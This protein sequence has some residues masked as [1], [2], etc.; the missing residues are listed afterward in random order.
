VLP[1]ILAALVLLAIAPAAASAA[2]GDY[3][4]Q[5]NGTDLP[6]DEELQ[7][8][9]LVLFMPLDESV[10]IALDAEITP[11]TCAGECFRVS[12][13]GESVKYR[14][15]SG[16]Y[17]SD[18]EKMYGAEVFKELGVYYVPAEAFFTAIGFDTRW[19]EETGTLS[20]GYDVELPSAQDRLADLLNIKKP[21]E[22]K[23]VEAEAAPAVELPEAAETYLDYTFENTTRYEYIGVTG[24]A[25]RSRTEEKNDV[26][27]RFNLRYMGKLSSGYDF[28]GVFRSRMTS[29]DE[30]NRGEL[31]KLELNWKKN[32]V[33]YTL[34]DVQPKFGLRYIMRNYSFQGFSYNRT[35]NLFTIQATV[36]KSP[37][38]LRRS[39]YARYINAFRLKKELSK[40]HATVLGAT[41]SLVKDTGSPKPGVVK[42]EN[43]VTGLDLQTRLGAP[44]SLNAEAAASHNSFRNL[45]SDKGTA[46]LYEL[47][48]ST[49][50]SSM[51][52]TYQ[53]TGAGFYSETSTFTRARTEAALLYNHKLGTYAMF[54]G[55]AKHKK[56][57]D[58]TTKIYPLTFSCRP[59][60]TR[61][62]FN[63]KLY[64]NFEKTSGSRQQIIDTREVQLRDALG[65]NR[66][67]LKV[68]RQKN[69]IPGRQLAYRDRKTLSVRSVLT[70]RL[71]SR[72]D[73]KNER[74]KKDRVSVSRQARMKLEFEPKAWT[75]WAAEVSRYY[76]TPSSARTATSLSYH[77]LDI[78]NDSE[79]TFE[80][81]FENYRDY[82][83]SSINLS[84]GFFR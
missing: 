27:D 20:V 77:K 26:H 3:S 2:E 29:E 56:I 61:D 35:N 6:V 70:D 22:G 47:S 15:G 21:E 16:E 24:D 71:A 46:F 79:W 5:I 57:K 63:M 19:N 76:N 72:V 54:G 75:E 74:W 36:G 9:D 38:R 73:L 25:S 59:I 84:Y 66:M 41:Y 62:N 50:R 53:K 13:Y 83:I 31:K 4:I 65:S 8:R 18:G 17:E 39:R 43:Y 44:W 68:S 80:F 30:L 7:M 32:K 40:E 34:Y 64:R 14:V 1:A 82:N 67:D 12:S 60:G 49:V 10:R 51:K 37:K 42:Q 45:K 33:D 52:A 69:K 23:P 11:V 28:I 55:G 48:R 81:K 58:R 78:Y